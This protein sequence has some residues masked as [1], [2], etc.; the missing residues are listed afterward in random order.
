MAL[1][2]HCDGL[3]YRHE[4]TW[5]KDRTE[6]V[7]VF[8]ARARP[9]ARPPTSPLSTRLSHPLAAILGW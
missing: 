9:L 1:T 8:I 3:C 7:A 6:P 2:L 4:R 5:G